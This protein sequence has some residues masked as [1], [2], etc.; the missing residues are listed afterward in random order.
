MIQRMRGRVTQEGGVEKAWRGEVADVAAAPEAE[1]ACLA[2]AQ[3]RADVFGRAVSGY[4]GLPGDSS[5]RH[6]SCPRAT[7]R[8][9]LRIRS[10]SRRTRGPT[11]MPSRVHGGHPRFRTPC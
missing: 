7:K 1:L 5:T 4:R 10:T 8:T 2:R 6:G 3:R 9:P 11:L